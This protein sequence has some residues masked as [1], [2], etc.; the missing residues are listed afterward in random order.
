MNHRIADL[1]IE[2]GWRRK[3]AEIRYKEIYRQSLA[4]ILFLFYALIATPSDRMIA[5]S[6]AVVVVIGA[7]IRV[8][9]AGVVMKNEQ[10]ATSGPYG[11]VRH[12]LYVGNILGVG[13]MTVISG[14]WWA[15]L[16]TA[17]FFWL[18]Y[19]TT[20][21]YEDSK[22]ENIFGEPWREWKGNVKALIPRL[23]PYSRDPMGWS[24]RRAAGRN[25]EAAIFIYV[26]V[27]LGIALSR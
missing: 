15:Y 4:I 20:I 14:T 26:L 24:I 27:C 7:L 13:G 11:Y 25:G 21:K 9:A 8:W 19:P 6:A 1:P 22:L 12:P 16:I 2:K 23:T 18:F 5:I 17:L 3:L 10:L